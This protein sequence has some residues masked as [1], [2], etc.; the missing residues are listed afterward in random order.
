MLIRALYFA[1]PRRVELR[2]ID[3]DTDLKDGE[4]L[5][6][7]EYSGISAGTELLAFRGELDPDLPL[8]ETI[9]P[10]AGTF[11]YPFR[12]GYS[13]VGRVEQTRGSLAAGS[14]AV[15]LHPH[16]DWFVARTSEVVALD[17]RHEARLATL[18]PLVET[19]LQITLDAGRVL[20]EHVVVVGLGAV[21]LLTAI[22]LGRSGASVL[23]AEPR[24]WRREAAASVGV[25]A[26]AP[27]DLAERVRAQT[28]GRGVPLLVELSGNPGA[29]SEGL[30]LLAHEGCALVASWYGNKEV[31]LPLGGSFH[32]RRLTLRSTQVSTIP[33][34]QRGHWTVARR[35]AAARDLLLEL[36]LRSLASHE[37]ALGEA[38][39][40]FEAID[41]QD[42]GILHVALR[43]G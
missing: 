32:R 27:H 29:L 24:G 1:A 3:L 31:R 16:Q 11:T 37:F 2:E 38:Q 22:L 43:H 20:A 25:E 10:L 23:A 28:D 15:A 26:V 6:R 30:A 35:R 13:C 36:P 7:T 5:V 14:L 9:G 4:A 17:G 12:Y 42:E 18:L 41:R 8:D 34:D 33:A 39:E 21:G 40:A 19:A